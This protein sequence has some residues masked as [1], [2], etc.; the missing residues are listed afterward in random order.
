M[1]QSVISAGLIAAI[2]NSELTK[3]HKG[4]I[5]IVRCHNWI[6]NPE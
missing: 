3:S 6:L 1:A 5:R 2:L 4:S